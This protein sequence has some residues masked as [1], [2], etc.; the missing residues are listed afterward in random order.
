MF[1]AADRAQQATGVPFIPQLAKNP[2]DGGYLTNSIQ[3]AFTALQ[4]GVEGKA[5][6]AGYVALPHY[7]QSRDKSNTPVPYYDKVT[8]MLFLFEDQ[9]TNNGGNGYGLSADDFAELLGDVF[10]QW[11]DGGVASNFTV[12]HCNPMELG[13]LPKEIAEQVKDMDLVVWALVLTGSMGFN[14]R[15]KVALPSISE[16][17]GKLALAC[18]TNGAALYY[19]TDGTL[20]TPTNG[21]LYTAPINPPST[22]LRVVGY[23]TNLIASDVQWWEP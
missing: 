12:E 10:Q 2:A 16:A 3:K 21:T 7:S 23:K 19:T 1:D 15:D 14:S 17:N 4:S 5:G 13:P 22:M 11:T 8:V 6:L 9:I 20:P 18:G